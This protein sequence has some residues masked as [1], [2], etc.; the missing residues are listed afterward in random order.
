MNLSRTSICSAACMRLKKGLICC[1]FFCMLERTKNRTRAIFSWASL[2]PQMTDNSVNNRKGSN[3]STDNACSQLLWHV[4]SNG[5]FHRIK[6][7]SLM[8]SRH[9]PGRSAT[10]A[11]GDTW[12]ISLIMVLW[13]WIFRF[14]GKLTPQMS[15][16]PPPQS[17][18]KRKKVGEIWTSQ[19]LP[20]WELRLMTV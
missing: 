16:T 18:K 14:K 6:Y 12:G 3:F 17:L 4:S 20:D 19:S 9:S 7:M 11:L 10:F 13:Q 2:G 8:W 1:V 15:L 5:F